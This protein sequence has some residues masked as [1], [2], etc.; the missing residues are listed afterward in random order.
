MQAHFFAFKKLLDNFDMVTF[1]SPWTILPQEAVTE[2]QIR[3]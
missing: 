2:E 3:P 1:I